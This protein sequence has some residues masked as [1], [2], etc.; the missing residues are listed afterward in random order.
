MLRYVKMTAVQPVHWSI[1]INWTVKLHHGYEACVFLFVFL[2]KVALAAH[3]PVSPCSHD[4]LLFVPF[5]AY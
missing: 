1:E 5:S 3:Q 2:I 4:L